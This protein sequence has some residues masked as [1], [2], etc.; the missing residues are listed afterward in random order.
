MVVT[1]EPRGPGRPDSPA[2]EAGPDDEGVPPVIPRGRPTLTLP[3]VAD[4][5]GVSLSTFKRKYRAAFTAAVAPVDKPL[6]P[7]GPRPQPYQYDEA[8]VDAYLTALRAADM[9]TAKAAREPL[10]ELPAGEHPDDLLT[11]KEAAAL[12]GVDPSTVRAYAVT[13]YLDSEEV[14][15]SFRV[16]RRVAEARRDAG[17]QRHARDRD[18]AEVAG[19]IAQAEQGKRPP[20]TTAEVA[21]HYK[22]PD[23]TARR[24]LAR[25]SEHHKTAHSDQKQPPTRANRTN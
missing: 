19:W 11:D 7:G 15:G 18:A 23:Y 21:A 8:Q 24:I 3:Q 16:R 10:P 20:V 14:N 1:E 6:K 17:D 25:A 22:V 12:L 4:R 2:D 5:F 9:D 13:G